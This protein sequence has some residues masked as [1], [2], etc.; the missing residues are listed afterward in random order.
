VA[1]FI[2]SPAMNLVQAQLEADGEKLSCL[3]G[4]QRLQ[5]P[6]TLLARLPALRSLAGRTVALG[7]RP[8][9][10]QDA[11]LAGHRGEGGVLRGRVVTTE[12]LGSEVLAHIE[13]AAEPVVTQE[14]LEVAGDTDRAL[15][16]DL[17]SE[18]GERRTT[19]V[20]RFAIETTV[21]AGDEAL[22]SVATDKLQFFDL[23]TETA[24]RG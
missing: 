7:V 4:S 11:V 20:C 24:V 23:E 22:V 2:G 8:E 5:L 15:A 6:D 16:E 18:A 1:S 3:I 21:R 13:V 10:L 19:F 9:H 14:V 17:R 12:L